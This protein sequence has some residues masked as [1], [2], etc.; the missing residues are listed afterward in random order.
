M[1]SVNPSFTT[2]KKTACPFC[3]YGCEFGVVFNDFGIQRIE[4]IADGAN[5]GRLC[6]RGSAAPLYVDHPKRLSMPRRKNRELSWSKVSKELKKMIERPQEVAITFDRNVTIEEYEFIMGFSEETGI[7]TIASTYLEPEHVFRRFVTPTLNL[8]LINN[9]DVVFILGDPFNQSPMISKSVINWKMNDRNHRLI[10][11]DSI[12]TH[13]SVFAHDFLRVMPG[14]EPAI[15]FGLAEAHSISKEVLPPDLN[16]DRIKEISSLLKKTEKGVI[17][18]CTSF[19]RPY[20]AALLAEGLAVLQDF[21]GLPVMPLVEFFGYNGNQHFGAIMELAKQKKVKHLINFGEL[22]PYYY[23]QMMSS[24]KSVNIFASTPL[25]FDGVTALPSALVLE[26]NGTLMTTFG[27]KTFTASIPPASGARTVQEILAMAKDTPSK[28]GAS[29]AVRYEV[30]SKTQLQE[31]EKKATAPLKK[32][33]KGMSGRLIG[34][35]IAFNFLGFFEEAQVKLNPRD[36]AHAGIRQ[37]DEVMVETNH[38]KINLRARLTPVVD[39]GIMAVPVEIPDIR[40]LFA[41]DVTNNIVNFGP[42]EVVVWRKG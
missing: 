30:D 22:F 33:K 23:P 37:N 6:P 15:L 35:K 12:G 28:S 42:T 20:D 17:I 29:G 5:E 41:F 8:E 39:R 24:L 18:A 10:V 11:L 34:E 25:K 16:T 19:G 3:S 9:A 4:Y 38:G 2:V 27:K 32:T 1:K 7:N 26:K 31:L 36:A 21:S 14:T 13:T 40:G